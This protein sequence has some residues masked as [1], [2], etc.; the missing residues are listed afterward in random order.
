M[1]TPFLPAEPGVLPVP[2][3]PLLGD[4]RSSRPPGSAATI[5]SRSGAAASRT[6][7]RFGKDA[8]PGLWAWEV[9]AAWFGGSGRRYVSRHHFGRLVG[10][11]SCSDWASY[12]QKLIGISGFM[13]LRPRC[14]FRLT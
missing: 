4:L 3:V 6:K 10:A 1:P 12:G 13:V 9:A 5:L 7:G 11:L 8:A 2:V 14:V